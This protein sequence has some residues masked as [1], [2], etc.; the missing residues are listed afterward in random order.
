MGTDEGD[1]YIHIVRSKWHCF[2]AT[3]TV[4]TAELTH[5]LL[6]KCNFS[7]ECNACIR[8]LLKT[9]LGLIQ[10]V[11]FVRCY[12][13]AGTVFTQIIKLKQSKLPYIIQRNLPVTE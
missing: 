8:T 1:M 7:W 11:G 2:R 12:Y 4:I 13:K 3:M 9:V 10:S 6:E 5:I